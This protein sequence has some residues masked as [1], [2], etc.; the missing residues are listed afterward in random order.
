M[1]RTRI[2]TKEKLSEEQ[3]LRNQIKSKEG[4]LRNSQ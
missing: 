4:K 3:M 1:E 2:L